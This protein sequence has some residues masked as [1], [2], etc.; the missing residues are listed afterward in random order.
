MDYIKQSMNNYKRTINDRYGSI[1]NHASNK[2]YIVINSGNRDRVLFP[3]QGS[4]VVDLR[5]RK[6]AISIMHDAICGTL[7]V[8][9]FRLGSINDPGNNQITTDK[10][11]TNLKGEINRLSDGSINISLG[12]TYH[13]YSF[14]RNPHY[15]KGVYLKSGYNYDEII[16]VI[17][18]IQKIDGHNAILSYINLTNNLNNIQKNCI[19][20]IMKKSHFSFLIQIMGAY[21]N[22]NRFVNYRLHN[23]TKGTV[24]V[25]NTVRI[26][27]V[28]AN[29]VAV[30]D[31][32]IIREWDT[33]DLITI[34]RG[35]DFI[36]A[37]ITDIENL[38]FTATFI[39]RSVADQ[40]MPLSLFNDNRNL[41]DTN[42]MVNKR[43]Y[44]RLHDIDA[45]GIGAPTTYYNIPMPLASI[46][47]DDTTPTI[48]K[49]TVASDTPVISTDDIIKMIKWYREDEVVEFVVV[50]EYNG[51]NAESLETMDVSN[52]KYVSGEYRNKN[53]DFRR[54]RVKSITL[55]RMNTTN[56]VNIMN[57]PFLYIQLI[58]ITSGLYFKSRTLSNDP[59]F[60]ERYQFRV[61]IHNKSDADKTSPYVYI[62][63]RSI[64]YIY[65]NLD[66][67][68]ESSFMFTITDNRGRLINFDSHHLTPYPINNS[69]QF[70]VVFE[71]E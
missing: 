59:T 2:Q 53:V 11:T 28:L 36:R 23:I 10:Y 24:S 8:A 56:G 62:Q 31:Q 48:V 32:N 12:D 1:D 25:P 58:P 71:I 4:F 39:N 69:H 34:R 50:D 44:V 18:E 3:N 66:L 29:N 61:N 67:E 49:F 20:S 13:S 65:T 63:T 51:D 64:Q 54:M 52:E 6:K 17:R 68:S 15:F 55:P 5:H 70:S 27:S 43:Y 35:V 42:T 14:Q 57:I 9:A 60:K 22:V 7:P 37:R 41:H 21:D 38:T 45:N 33:N 40:M 26:E 46:H 30:V 19:I 47:R 16:G